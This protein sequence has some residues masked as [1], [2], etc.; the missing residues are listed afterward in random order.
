MKKESIEL[1]FVQITQECNL[2]CFYCPFSKKNFL[3]KRKNDLKK[4]ADSL[5]Y[6]LKSEFFERS[7][8]ELIIYGG[9]PLLFFGQ[10]KEIVAKYKKYRKSGK[11][12]ICTNGV[13]L[14]E[15]IISYAENEVIN[16]AINM[17]GDF[18]SVRKNKS[19]KIKD[20]NKLMENLKNLSLKKV[21]YDFSTTLTPYFIENFNDQIVF[22]ESLKPRM[23]GFNFLRD[24]LSQQRFGVFDSDKYFYKA[25]SLVFKY[26]SNINFNRAKKMNAY[27]NGK[28]IPDCICSGL[29]LTILSDGGYTTCGIFSS[30][31]CK[32]ATTLSK[33]IKDNHDKLFKDVNFESGVKD[34][35]TF[36]GG[37]AKLSLSENSN[38]A[39]YN[40]VVSKEQF[41]NEK[42]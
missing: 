15:Q 11:V 41:I 23:I 21:P 20:W 17:D 42:I 16:L 24:K 25:T 6:I 13:L 36:G 37:C 18:D 1:L 22:L 40:A 31:K 3:I 10:I 5:D 7:F 2:D 33:L 8:N 14:N 26:N 30:Q 28:Q 38:F 19:L 4:Q 32:D 9:E 35:S 29:G 27:I 39:Y 34:L 12:T